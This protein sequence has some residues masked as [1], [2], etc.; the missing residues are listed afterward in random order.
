MLVLCT[1]TCMWGLWLINL[2]A[3]G[4]SHWNT[5]QWYMP[6]L[7][8]RTF[9]QK[10]LSSSSALPLA[11]NNTVFTGNTDMGCSDSG[12]LITILPSLTSGME[13]T[14]EMG[15]DSSACFFKMYIF[16][17]ASRSL[18]GASTEE[19]PRYEMPLNK[20]FIEGWSSKGET[21]EEGREKVRG[22]RTPV[23]SSPRWREQEGIIE[24]ERDISSVSYCQDLKERCAKTSC[25]KN[26]IRVHTR[27]CT[28]IYKYTC[29]I[30]YNLGIRF[31]HPGL[32]WCTTVYTNR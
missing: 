29:T 17:L 12:S 26:D 21:G 25:G 28:Y 32:F 19:E 5:W 7:L 30:I 8:W 23:S 27:T 18:T 20:M 22:L 2:T 31:A 11:Q 24:R 4:I 13:R 10:Q 15:W 14:T 3:S 1:C 6:L 9:R 16:L